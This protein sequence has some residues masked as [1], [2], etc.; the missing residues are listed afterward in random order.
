MEKELNTLRFNTMPI[1]LLGLKMFYVPVLFP[2]S[3][4]DKGGG[5]RN[6]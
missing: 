4:G 1:L 3:E 6:L 2:P 5:Q